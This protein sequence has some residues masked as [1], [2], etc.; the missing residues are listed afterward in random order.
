MQ[1][2]FSS[3]KF[4]PVWCFC[5]C[6]FVLPLKPSLAIV[7]FIF[8]LISCSVL[9]YSEKKLF[10]TFK[11]V[12]NVYKHRL[13]VLAIIT[14]VW[15][16]VSCFWSHRFGY[17]V[18]ALS[19]IILCIFAILL[20]NHFFQIFP[21]MYEK[22]LILFP[23]IFS[24]F[25]IFLALNTANHMGFIDIFSKFNNKI[26]IK[27]CLAAA[28]MVFFALHKKSVLEAI[29]VAIPTAFFCIKNHSDASGLA[30]L[31][32]LIAI[33]AYKVLPKISRKIFIYLPPL[34]I[35]LTPVV[36]S[37]LS[38]KD[39]EDSFTQWDSSYG[40]RIIILDSYLQEIKEKPFTGNGLG[41]SRKRIKNGKK[42]KKLKGHVIE[43]PKAAYHPHNIIVQL[44]YEVGLLGSIM[45]TALWLFFWRN[46]ENTINATTVSFYASLFTIGSL[47]VGLWQSWYLVIIC[48]MIVLVNNR[49]ECLSDGN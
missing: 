38:L 2:A 39:Y 40:H 43:D 36:L 29:C 31:I 44:W 8:L 7:N 46:R 5:L 3:F 49:K 22:M 34:L 13:G 11:P 18:L 21:K 24:L 14:F 20:L 19:K 32:G 6:F 37:L 15:F 42:F 9:L 30:I 1:R 48:L 47:A 17:G 27:V 4:L 41:S 28:L 45:V 12:R 25:F 23:A 33:V 10:L 16:L 26:L 35:I